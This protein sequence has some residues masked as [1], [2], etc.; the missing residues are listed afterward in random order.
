M[1]R[2]MICWLSSL[3]LLIEKKSGIGA[4][5]KKKDNEA[6]IK[7]ESATAK[8]RDAKVEKK[9]RY[10]F[11]LAHTRLYEVNVVVLKKKKRGAN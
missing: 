2:G 10:V 6:N 1:W 4:K 11:T 8:H 3:F 5:K 7:R 9:D